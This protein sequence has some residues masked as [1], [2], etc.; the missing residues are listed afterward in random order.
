MM[1]MRCDPSCSP[2]GLLSYR[3]PVEFLDHWYPHFTNFDFVIPVDV[4][5]EKSYVNCYLDSSGVPVWFSINKLYFVLSCWRAQKRRR[6][7]MDFENGTTFVLFKY[8]C[9]CGQFQSISVSRI[10]LN[11]NACFLFNY[12]LEIWFLKEITLSTHLKKFKLPLEFNNFK[13]FVLHLFFLLSVRMINL[14]T[15]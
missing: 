6:S 1:M 9:E 11:S 8:K 12:S 13:K 14:V 10:Y 5:R 3:S 2:G 15:H 7:G 4:I